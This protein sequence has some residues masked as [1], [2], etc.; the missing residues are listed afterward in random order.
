VSDDSNVIMIGGILDMMTSFYLESE[1]VRIAT[2]LEH[3][4]LGLS[5]QE[6]ASNGLEHRI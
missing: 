1:K 4:L 2:G 6:W 5:L 3:V